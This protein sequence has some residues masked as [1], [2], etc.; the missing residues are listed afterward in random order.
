MFDRYLTDNDSKLIGVGGFLPIQCSKESLDNKAMV[1]TFGPKGFFGYSPS[2][3]SESMWWSTVQADD[4]PDESRIS[5]TDLRTQLKQH[6]GNWKDPFIQ[7][8]IME[9]QVDHVYP[10]WTTPELPR[11]SQDGLILVGDAAHALNPTS[12]QGSSQALEDAKTLSMCLSR[13]LAGSP[14]E[15]APAAAV[16]G[17]A[18][19]YYNVRSPRLRAIA[20]R[21]AKLS[22]TKKDLN[23]VEELVTCAFFWLLGKFPAIG[24]LLIGDVNKEL[25]E[26]DV[27]AEIKKYLRTMR[28]SDN[29][30][31]ELAGASA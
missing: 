6:H 20:A 28:D 3:A 22:S 8:I 19:L 24:K 5:L 13:F 16:D 11:W 30:A 14:A 2:S 15:A 29:R 23:I 31:S 18:E 25:Y 27:H 12:G 26:W 17:A 9:A 1:F 21:T 10:C 7:D 4:L